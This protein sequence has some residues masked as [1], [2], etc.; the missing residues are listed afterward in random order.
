MLRLENWSIPRFARPV[1]T[2]IPPCSASVSQFELGYVSRNQKKP[3]DSPV[4]AKRR[5]PHHLI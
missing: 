1:G 5:D 2:L 3:T 4:C